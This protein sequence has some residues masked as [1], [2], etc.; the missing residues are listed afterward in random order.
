MWGIFNGYNITRFKYGKILKQVT[1]IRREIPG[2]LKKGMY[3]EKGFNTILGQEKL[4]GN[5]TV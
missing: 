3:F 5:L 2:S 1:V 4:P